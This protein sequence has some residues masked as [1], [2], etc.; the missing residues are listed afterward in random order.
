MM[1]YVI[2]ELLTTGHSVV[3]ESNSSHPLMDHDLS[4]FEQT[5]G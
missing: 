5:F 3:V 2:G 4:A 1:D